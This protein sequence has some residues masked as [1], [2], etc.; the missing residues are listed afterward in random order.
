VHHGPVGRGG[1]RLAGVRPCQ[2][3]HGWSIAARGRK[4]GGDV[5]EPI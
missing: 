4:G 3:L 2:R 5:G 1:G